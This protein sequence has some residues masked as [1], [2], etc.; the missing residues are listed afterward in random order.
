M[1]I[2]PPSQDGRTPENHALLERSRRAGVREAGLSAAA[3]GGGENYL[4]A[5]ALLLHATPVQIGLLSALPQLIGAWTQILSVKLL[6][7]IQHRRAIGMA[8]LTGQAILWL[9]ILILPLAAPT[10][11]PWLLI[12]AAVLYFLFGH[13]GA[14]AWASL[15]TDLIRDDQRG[16]YFAHRATVSAVVNFVAMCAA[17][18]VLHLATSWNAAWAGFALI[19]LGAAAAKAVA[20]RALGRIDDS[21]AFA[22]REAELRLWD[23]LRHERH[24]DFLRFLLFSGVMHAC[25]LISGPFFV[26]YMLR[27]LQLSYL[28]YMVWM[29][30]ALL[31]Q[32]L[33]LKPWGRISDRYGNKKVLIVTGLLVPFLPM[34]YLAG[35]HLTFLVL[36]NFFGGLVWAG[37]SLGLQ[38]YV[39]DAVRAEDRAKGVALWNTINAIGWFAGSMAGSWL[40]IVVPGELHVWGL[41]LAP[42]SNL[43]IVFFLSG[44]LRLITSLALLGTFGEPRQVQAISHRALLAELPL[45]ESLAAVVGGRPRRPEG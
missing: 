6:H 10:Q 44:L 31:G 40:A 8:S 25:V 3:L 12:G 39:F 13:F 24:S 36:V 28:E 43:P 20:A 11:A 17:G 41:T 33:S 14:P 35:T 18:L 38:N 34:L 1:P 22:T 27:D 9:P 42:A 16:T 15:L 19:F 29:A 23:F 32:F 7:S 26:I 5:F 30:A 2:T 4:S 37:L 45:V 21:A